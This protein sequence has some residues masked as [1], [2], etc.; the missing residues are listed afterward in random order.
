[1]KDY[2]SDGFDNPAFDNNPASD[3]Y[4]LREKPDN[5]DQE[6]FE[7]GPIYP[8]S[9][10]RIQLLHFEEPAERYQSNIHSTI[11]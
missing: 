5:S 11:D 9:D 6:A 7:D 2:D 8:K 4:S 1:L 3:S 10:E